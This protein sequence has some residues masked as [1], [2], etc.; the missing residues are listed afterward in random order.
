MIRL[1]VEP[2][3]PDV[4][5]WGWDE[6]VEVDGESYDATEMPSPNEEFARLLVLRGLPDR[7][8]EPLLRDAQASPTRHAWRVGADPTPLEDIDDELMGKAR[9]LF[10]R[11]TID[12]GHVYMTFLAERADGTR[13]LIG[14]AGARRR[15]S[16]IYDSHGWLVLGRLLAMPE[17]R[18]RG[19]GKHFT[20][21]Y[22]AASQTFCGVPAVG[23]FLPTETEQTVALCNK[24][25]KSGALD[26]A[27]SG[28]KHW[29]LIDVDFEIPVFMA[30]Y[31]GM[32]EWILEQLGEARRGR[33][34]SPALM[35]LL[36]ASDDA[37]RSGFDRKA[38][39][40]LGELF[41]AGRADL[42]AA[43]RER[44]GF[45]C[46]LDFLVSCEQVGV[47]EG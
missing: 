6:R 34:S 44:R 7:Y 22:F 28:V 16:P 47:L 21:F 42:E 27:P 24:A 12:Y 17:F 41:A 3:Q 40:E 9:K 11:D 4:D 1:G 31:P 10:D 38:G 37:L 19:Y 46:L 26:M 2:P 32:K 43:T 5:A 35:K 36:D 23:C 8:L 45:A 15:I 29:V 33:A 13:E 14:G 30:F 20:L 25:V 39:G 18:G